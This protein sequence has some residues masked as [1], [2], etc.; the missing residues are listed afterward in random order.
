MGPR[1]EEVPPIGIP[2]T[3]EEAHT[4]LYVQVREKPGS[5]P[6][7]P[8]SALRRCIEPSDMPDLM[9]ERQQVGQPPHNFGFVYESDGANRAEEREEIRFVDFFA[10]SGGF[11]QGVTQEPKMKGAAAVECWDTACKTFE[12]NNPET[13]VY[14]ETVED[15]LEKNGPKPAD[16]RK[17]LQGSVECI[18]WSSPCQSF[19][20]LNRDVDHN[21]EKD[22]YRK[23][24]SLKFVDAMQSTGALIGVLENVEGMWAR[25][26]VYFLKKIVLDLLRTGH[27]VRVRLHVSHAFGDPQARPRLLIYAAKKFVEMPNVIETH[28]P[29]MHPYM[30][31]GN[32]FNA[33]DKALER[34]ENDPDADPLPNLQGSTTSKPGGE[35]GILNLDRPAG[36]ISCGGR[37]WHPAED[38][39]ITVREAAAI[40]SYPHRYEFVGSV[41]DQYKQVG[42]AV[43][44][45]MATAVARAIAESLRFVYDEEGEGADDDKEETDE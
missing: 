29:G 5:E 35:G 8:L 13:P 17:N 12:K 28:G 32:A 6:I 23:R 7:V 44:G 36:T 9:F 22:L 37:A 30:T 31:V 24:L 25:P 10:G 11:H 20:R 45:R 16:F 1:L 26:N 33:L 42:N 18:L 40:Q 2:A 43:P 15:F 38:R 34:A 27:Q 3:Y 21:G 4:D 39:A 14:C 41:T 19:S